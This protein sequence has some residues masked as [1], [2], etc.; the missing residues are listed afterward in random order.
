MK[1]T[2]LWFRRDLRLDDN[3]ALEA[4]V[5]FQSPIIPVYVWGFEDLGDRPLGERSAWWLQQSLMR[6]DLNLKIVGNRLTVITGNPLSAL[7]E[8]VHRFDARAIFW[9]K[10]YEPDIIK[11]D[12]SVRDKFIKTG[13]KTHSFGG[14]SL[15]DPSQILSSESRPF[16]RFNSFWKHVSGVPV[17][18]CIKPS[19][20]L[21]R[22]PQMM[23]RNPDLANLKESWKMPRTKKL[24]QLWIPGEIQAHKTL[25]G[26]V[27]TQITTYDTDRNIP[28]MDGGSKLSSHLHFG[29]ISPHK[30]WKRV[31]TGT[32]EGTGPK[33]FLRQLAWRDFAYYVMFH[34]P[35]ITKTSYQS[36]FD[37]FPWMQNSSG[38]ELWKSGITGYPLVDAG[39]R[40][41]EHTGFM[42]NRIR[43]VVASFL[44]KHLRIHW[45]EG[46][47]HFEKKLVDADLSNNLMGW[48]W[49][50]GSGLDASPYF[51]IFNPVLQGR[52]FD[53]QGQYV[54]Q[55]V[56]EISRLPDRW[57]HEPWKANSLDLKKAGV[58]LGKTYPL[59]IV[60]HQTARS[61][62]LFAYR[63]INKMRNDDL[64][65]K[66][67]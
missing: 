60:D 23:V 38:L 9:N 26:F 48:Q 57:I 34:N 53:Q 61:E 42:H 29:E 67:G 44:T 4:A 51:R 52:R 50:A 27:K 11:L 56:P 62:A 17:F 49:V 6:L 10:I 36:K 65:S 32:R 1:P 40:E 5:R 20:R 39:M 14:S 35:K 41:L 8:M 37:K 33:E 64:N 3:L 46:V 15:W 16:R 55:W 43:M 30:V 18:E 13:L 45:L 58:I 24:E 21:T 2:I 66:L 31:L 63:S 22:S 47:S 54:R 12:Q 59:P 7:A 28:A 19:P 25:E